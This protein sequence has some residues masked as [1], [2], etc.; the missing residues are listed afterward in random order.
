MSGISNL[1]IKY[2]FHM[3]TD[4]YIEIWKECYSSICSITFLN[5]KGDRIGSG[6]GFKHRNFLVTNNHVYAGYLKAD[7][8]QIKFVQEDGHTPI[9]IKSFTN[10]EFQNLLED[11]LPESGWDFAILRLDD[12]EFDSIPSLEIDTDHMPIIG[13]IVAIMGFPFENGNLSISQGIISSRFRKSDIKYLQL[14]VNVNQGNS[15]GPLID[16][17]SHKV[18]GI[19]TRKATGLTVAFD[20]LIDTFHTNAL[21]MENG[22]KN[23]GFV[24]NGINIGAAI[25]VTQ[26]QFIVTATEI[27]R[28]ANVGI[29][30]AYELDKITEFFEKNS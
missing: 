18:I 17:H 30:Y 13:N 26:R 10:A 14:D 21:L 11:G 2:Y 4:T 23:S 7:T 15:G 1:A 24:Q 6:T 25:G 28:S 20:N 27:K 16:A 9:L 22:S 3:K 29:G 12:S 19:V 8:V 5:Q